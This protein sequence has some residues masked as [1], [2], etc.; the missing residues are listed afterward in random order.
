MVSVQADLRTRGKVEAERGE[1]SDKRSTL[2]RDVVLG[3]GLC[4][5]FQHGASESVDAAEVLESVS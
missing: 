5:S 4:L 1:D 2:N 3:H